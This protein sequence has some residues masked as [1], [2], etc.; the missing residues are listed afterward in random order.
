MAPRCSRPGS[1]AVFSHYLDANET[2]TPN[3]IKPATNNPVLYVDD[4]GIHVGNHIYRAT[5]PSTSSP[6]TGVALNITGGTAFGYS[7]WLNSQYIGSYLGLS[8]S[9]IGAITLSFADATLQPDGCED[10]I[11]VV[12]MDN[13]GHDLRAE[14]VDPRG[15]TNATLLGPCHGSSS[16][17]S[18]YAFTSW[19][20]AGTAGRQ[21]NIDPVRG[22]FNEGGLYAERIGAHLPGFPDGDWTETTSTATTTTLAVPGAGIRVFRTVVPLH[23]PDG[24]DVSVSFRLTAPGGGGGNASSNAT[25]APT[26]PGY[27]SRV[28]ALLFVNGYQYGRFSAYIGNQID[29]PVPPGV[30]DYDG[31]NTVAVTVWS[32]SAE[33]AEVGVE[34]DLDYVHSSSFDMKFNSTYLR[35]GWSSDRWAYA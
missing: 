35:P 19:K 29:F 3:A 21:R 30:L 12:V 9:E 5:F 10:N 24:L 2:T 26:A 4:Y 34:W 16:S 32:Q 25:F 13:S 27:S 7:A 1:N 15:I 28:R 6:P 8:Y 14:A 20:I 22:P 31:D 18:G 33:G 23:V 17:G 11:L